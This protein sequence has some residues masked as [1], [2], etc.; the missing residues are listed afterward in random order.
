M[1]DRKIRVNIWIRG[2]SKIQLRK[3]AAETDESMGEVVERL[4]ADEYGRVIGVSQHGSRARPA[5]A[6]V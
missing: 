2:Q 6:G 3:I 1:S 5:I 4:L